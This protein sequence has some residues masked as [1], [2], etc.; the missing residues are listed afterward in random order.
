MAKK[1]IDGVTYDIMEGV[2]VNEYGAAF[3]KVV[4]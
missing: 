4:G 1:K 3:K 2:R